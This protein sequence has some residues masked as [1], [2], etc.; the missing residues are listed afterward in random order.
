M[1]TAAI[2][3]CQRC[4]TILRNTRKICPCCGPEPEP[5]AEETEHANPGRR[6]VAAKAGVRICPVCMTSVPEEQMIDQDNQK[7]CPTCAENMKNKAIRKA[8]GGPEKK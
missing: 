7:I 2:E 4:G 6:V 8:S 3:R 1:A 5:S